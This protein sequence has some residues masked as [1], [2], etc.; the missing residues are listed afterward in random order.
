MIF[1]AGDPHITR[2]HDMAQLRVWD[3]IPE[4]KLGP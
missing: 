3:K 2:A 4:R 1:G